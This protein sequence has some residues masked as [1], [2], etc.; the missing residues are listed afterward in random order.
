MPLF[1]QQNLLSDDSNSTTN[2]V[3]INNNDRQHPFK[4]AIKI[5]LSPEF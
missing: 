1:K 4:T 5:L 3:N 2:S